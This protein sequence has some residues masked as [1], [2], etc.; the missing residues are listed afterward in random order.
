[1]TAEKHREYRRKCAST[2]PGRIRLPIGPFEQ[3]IGMSLEHFAT[4]NHLS[5][6]TIRSWRLR[7]IKLCYA[8]KLAIKYTGLHPWSI[9]GDAWWADVM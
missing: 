6:V 3:I 1:M 4:L 8:D 7:G 2:L 5:S 9:W